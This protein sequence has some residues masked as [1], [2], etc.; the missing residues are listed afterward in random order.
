[1]SRLALLVAFV[2]MLGAAGPA[3]PSP[4]AGYALVAGGFEASRQPDGNSVVVDAL[5]V[6]IIVDTGRPIGDRGAGGESQ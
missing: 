2:V 6:A 1:M 5:V 3:V 4:P